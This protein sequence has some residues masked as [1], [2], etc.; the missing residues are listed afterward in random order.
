M[1]NK[2][3]LTTDSSR[4]VTALLGLAIATLLAACADSPRRGAPVEDRALGSKT[5]PT[6]LPAPAGGSAIAEVKPLPGAENAGKPG[7]YTV[8]PRDTLIQIALD[9]GLNWRDVAKWN[10]LDKPNLIEVG[11]VLRVV[12]PGVDAS[13]A[14]TRPVAPT[15]TEPPRVLP[16][17]PSA[18]AVA[19]GAALSPAPAAAVAKAPANVV[20]ETDDDINWGWPTAWSMVRRPPNSW[21]PRAVPTPTPCID[22]CVRWQVERCVFQCSVLTVRRGQRHFGRSRQVWRLCRRGTGARA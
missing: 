21:P 9:N 22:C 3:H 19:S 13:V 10:N 15:K 20:R 12:P 18:S 6:P 5:Q 11:Q 17:A 1:Q 16:V 8:K 14:V 7:Y 2:T 4:L